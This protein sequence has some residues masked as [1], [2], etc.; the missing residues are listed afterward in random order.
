MSDGQSDDVRAALA[1]L[2]DAGFPLE[3]IRILPATLPDDAN[4]GADTDDDDPPIDRAALLAACL[5]ELADGER[6]AAKDIARDLRARF[7]GVTRKL[8]NSV[9]SSESRDNVAY[10][11][12]TFTYRLGA[13][14]EGDR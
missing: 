8:V 3:R 13:S 9:L 2:R 7:P 14:G 5:A 6:H 1:I 10:D 11:K 12:A 4:K